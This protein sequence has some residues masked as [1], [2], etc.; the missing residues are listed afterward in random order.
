MM[1]PHSEAP[2][3]IE[4]GGMM[5]RMNGMK[6]HGGKIGISMAAEMMHIGMSPIT[7]Q[8][9]MTMEKNGKKSSGPMRKH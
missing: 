3:S 8:S 2:R 5:I 1:K 4:S 9:G 7:M 6:V